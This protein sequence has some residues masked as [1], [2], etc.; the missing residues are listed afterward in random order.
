[1]LKGLT[2]KA[3]VL[4]LMAVIILPIFGGF[5]WLLSSGSADVVSQ[6]SVITLAATI[7]GILIL[8]AMPLAI[9][10]IQKI[11][12]PLDEIKQGVDRILDGDYSVCF[13]CEG[14]D[15][16]TE[17]RLSL[18]SLISRLKHNLGFAQGVL[19]G[20][21]TP[22][23]V[24]NLEEQLT[25]T[26]PGLIKILQHDGKPEEYYGQNVAH[27]FYGDAS[28]RTV[29]RDSLEKHTVTNREVEFTGRKGGK[30]NLNIHASP[31]FDLNG[32][33][34]GALCI[35][36]DLTE[37]RIREAEILAKN[38]A[39][40]KAAHESEAISMDVAQLAQDIAKQIEHTSHEVDRQTSRAID[41][42]TA[43]EEMNTA[44]FE[45]A[46][47]A[48]SAAERATDAR[49]KAQEG[50][51]VVEQAM[52]AIAEVSRQS[53]ALRASMS[54]LGDQ[55]NGIGQVMNVITDIADQT[56]LLALNAAIEAARAGEAGRG[57]AVVADEV[58]KLAEKTMMATKEVGSAIKAIQEGA[59]LNA[60]SVDSAVKAVDSSR[61]LSAASG[62]ALKFIVA[63][64]N[65]TNDQVQ[66]IATAA[67][68][69]SATSE[70]INQSVDEVKNIS[71]QASAELNSTTAGIH[72][73][74]QLSSKLREIIK[75]IEN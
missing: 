16:L 46:R 8:V 4:I 30:R 28:R 49:N 70:H 74:A 45:V 34:M 52:A 59:R 69:Q 27:F 38:E 1:M 58:R 44:V 55:A 20:I 26:N 29:L 60:E 19:K 72:E 63:L 64:V 11:T 22:F 2:V 31:L 43:M 42:A 61:A 51:T 50:F 32:E 17:M 33:I 73:L 41:T 54:E 13:A 21:D 35:Y 23:V 57:F 48:S 15:E 66:A 75:N 62:D 39:I 7:L 68:E 5:G 53:L 67:E 10:L 40:S 24:V 12:T 18:E 25:Y 3:L 14:N 71:Q 36:Q 6:S 9:V 56:N 37:L 47:S 65:D